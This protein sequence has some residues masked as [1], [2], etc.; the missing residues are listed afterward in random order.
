MKVAFFSSA[1]NHHQIPF[2]NEMYKI[3]GSDFI[4]VATE[5]MGEQHKELGFVEDYNYPYLLKMYTSKENY[6]EAYKISQEADVMIAGVFPLKFLYDRMKKNKLTFRYSERYFKEGKVCLLSPRAIYRIYKANTRYRNKNL[7][8][9]CAGGYTAED[10]KFI[11]AYPNKMFKWGYFPEFKHYNLDELINKKN[12]FSYKLVWV[13]RFIDWK[14]TEDAIEIARLLKLNGYKFHL[15]IIGCGELEEYLKN[16]VKLNQLEDIVTF[17]GS[18][19]TEQVRQQMEN[20]NIYLF[21]SDTRE[22]WGVVLNEAMNSGC[23]VVASDAIGSVSY[24]IEDNVNG[25]IYKSGDIRDLFNKVTMLIDNKEK[26]VELGINAYKTIAVKWNAKVAS[27]RFL[28]ISKQLLKG[29]IYYYS[30]GPMSK[31]D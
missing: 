11:R 31:A 10:M 24:L 26:Q 12:N 22:G 27:K 25:L 30:N 15:D 9:L 21:S 29:R 2:C 8:M 3:L 4:F 7:Y 23:A 18:M 6:D 5:K 13:G 20:A 14:H 16:I 17:L 19:S 1:L 28:D